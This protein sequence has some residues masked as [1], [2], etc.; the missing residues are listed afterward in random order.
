[1]DIIQVQTNFI[2]TERRM[3]QPRH[4]VQSINGAPFQIN[5]PEVQGFKF[6]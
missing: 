5:L 2:K 3:N 1:M 6:H 4:A